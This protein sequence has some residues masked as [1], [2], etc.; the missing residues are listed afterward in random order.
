MAHDASAHAAAPT[1]PAQPAATSGAR[2]VVTMGTL[3]LVCAVLIVAA[4]RF[5]LPAIERNKAAALERAVFEVI[6]AAT[7]K[8]VF[9]EKDGRLVPAAQ[10]PGGRKYYAGYDHDG[11]LAG[12]AVEASGQG[13][14]GIVKIIYGYAPA[15][16]AVVGM[17]VLESRETP[18]L[19]TKI[20]TEPAFRANF[21]SLAVVL[22]ASAT[23]I[24]NPVVL[25]KPHEKTEPWQ[26]EAITGATISSRTIADILR[27]STGRT[28]P[29]IMSDLDALKGQGHE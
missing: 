10:A 21:D 5:T 12:V 15:K 28:V 29:V 9:A 26:V 18:G 24:A 13:F 19:G 23:G 1:Q 14:A 27:A 2:M 22:D 20:E 25:V 17:K 6:P 8:V 16:S 11:G 4:F 7:T 3:G